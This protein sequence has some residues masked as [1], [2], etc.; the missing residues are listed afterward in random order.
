MNQVTNEV[1]NYITE[2]AQDPSAL[3]DDLKD[4][5]IVVSGAGNPGFIKPEHLKKGAALIDAGTSELN[6]K[7]TGDVDPACADIAS[8]FTPVPGGVGPVAVAMIFRNL[9]NLLG[10]R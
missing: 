1:T 4:A 3:K 8:V 2:K 7:I 6:K 9:L 10:H 5:D